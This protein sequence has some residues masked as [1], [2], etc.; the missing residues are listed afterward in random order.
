ML[1]RKDSGSSVS[2]RLFDGFGPWDWQTAV[3]SYITSSINLYLS[4]IEDRSKGRKP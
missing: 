2:G 3:L 4:S 1:Q